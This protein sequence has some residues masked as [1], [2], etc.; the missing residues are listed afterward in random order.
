MKVVLVGGKIGE[1]LD[2]AKGGCDPFWAPA[3]IL[4]LYQ[5]THP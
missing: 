2:A 3:L 1:A 4:P 5:S